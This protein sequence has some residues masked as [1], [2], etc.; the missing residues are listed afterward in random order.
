VVEQR[1]TV[2]VHELLCV[3]QGWTGE[4]ST[5]HCYSSIAERTRAPAPRATDCSSWIPVTLTH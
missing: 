2:D 1:S 5:S 4:V 3:V